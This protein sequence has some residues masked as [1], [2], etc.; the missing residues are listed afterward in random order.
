MK[1]ESEFFEAKV[2]ESQAKIESA[3][4]ESEKEKI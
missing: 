4:E 1:T 2:T 3:T